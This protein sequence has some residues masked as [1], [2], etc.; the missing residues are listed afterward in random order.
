[1]GL[2]Q[3]S[4]YEQ[5]LEGGVQIHAY[6]PRFLHAKF[7]TFDDSIAL[8]GSSN[9]DIR[10]FQLNEEISLLM[11]DPAVVAQLQELQEGYFKNSERVSLEKW[12]QR[13]EAVR[14]LQNVA[15]LADALL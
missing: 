9:M 8:I 3:R 15:R 6:M 2:A 14:M 4:Y 7:L 12:R 10:S 13:P 11:H 5:L 1:V